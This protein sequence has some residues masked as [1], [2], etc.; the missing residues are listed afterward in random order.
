MEVTSPQ[1]E[2]ESEQRYKELERRYNAALNEVEVLRRLFT[3]MRESVR[4]A[5]ISVD[6][7]EA[8]WKA[9]CGELPESVFVQREYP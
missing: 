9:A 3:N 6:A 1:P 2:Q 5:G 7:L 8:Q 4:Q